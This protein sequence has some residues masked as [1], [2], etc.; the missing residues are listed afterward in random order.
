MTIWDSEKF[1]EKI[2]EIRPIVIFVSGGEIT[3]VYLPESSTEP[4]YLTIQCDEDE[5]TCDSVDHDAFIETLETCGYIPASACEPTDF[6]D[7]SICDDDE[8]LFED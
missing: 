3:E 8:C 2:E 5:D 7:T 6:I 1:M 4:Q